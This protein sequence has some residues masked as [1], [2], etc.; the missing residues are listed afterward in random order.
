MRRRRSLHLIPALIDR[1][2]DSF[3]N[4]LDHAGVT[5]AVSVSGLNPGTS[6]GRFEFPDRTTSNDELAE[7]EKRQ[8]GR[9]LAVGGIDVS[10]TFHN[11][12]EEAKR[13]VIELGMKALTIEPGRAP[14][15][16]VDDPQLFP[17]YDLCQDLNVTLIPNMG[18]KSG[19]SL[20][21]AHPQSIEKIAFAFPNLRIICGHGCYPFVREAIL[22]ACRHDNIWLAPSGYFFLL[23]HDDWMQAINK[24]IMNFSDRFLFASGYPLNPI[25]AYVQRFLRLDWNPSVLEKILYRNAFEALGL[26]HNP[27]LSHAFGMQ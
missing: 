10:N 4:E 26:R 25:S 23:G 6:F 21:Y 12:F 2:E 22:T 9:F 7:I 13:C 19:A 15:C 5:M 14:G 8:G 27:D 17:F 1:S 18:P 3:F 11:S 16:S 24:D 20:A